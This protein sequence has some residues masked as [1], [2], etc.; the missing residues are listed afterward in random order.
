MTDTSM[1]KYQ[2]GTMLDQLILLQLHAEDPNCPCSLTGNKQ[3]EVGEY[4]EPKHLRAVVA[5]ARETIAMEDDK[6]RI[7]H[8]EVVVNEGTELLVK[9][10]A[11]LCGETVDFG[12]YAS[13]ARDKRKPLE[14]WC[15]SSFCGVASVED[16]RKRKRIR[17][18]KSS[19]RSAIETALKLHSKHTPPFYIF[20][21]AYGYTIDVHKPPHTQSYIQ[22]N[23]DGSVFRR[24]WTP[25]GID[26]YQMKPEEWKSEVAPISSSRVKMLGRLRTK[27]SGKL[28]EFYVSRKVYNT[29]VKSAKEAGWN[30]ISKLKVPKDVHSRYSMIHIVPISDLAEYIKSEEGKMKDYI[31]DAPDNTD[32]GSRG[33]PLIDILYNKEDQAELGITIDGKSCKLVKDYYH[34]RVKP[35]GYFDPRSFRAVKPRKGVVVTIGCKKG[36]WSPSKQHCKIGTEAQR[37]MYHKRLYAEESLNETSRDLEVIKKSIGDYDITKGKTVEGDTHSVS[38]PLVCPVEENND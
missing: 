18:S 17:Y 27:F 22:V 10:E 29:I 28:E 2:Y 32:L 13:W 20:A 6:A 24:T 36:N 30:F 8:L 23:N 15:Y 7:K 33:N 21:T 11:I 14:D 1:L 4:C 31:P 34:C 9:M 12:E 19:L 16:N 37:I 38:V 3:G 25:E 26:F 35:K 5:L